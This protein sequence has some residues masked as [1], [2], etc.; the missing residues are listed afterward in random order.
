MSHERPVVYVVDDDISVLEALKNLIRS[1]GLRVETFGSAQEFFS[2]QRSGAPGCLVLDV[3]LPGLSGLDLQR[4]LAEAHIEL[5]IVF[6]T[7]HGDIR[8]SVQPMKA[9]AREF[10]VKPFRR[11]ALVDAAETT[12]CP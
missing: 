5:P 4:K 10:L 11:P 6:I 2:S 7:G 3:R 12:I 9:G 1:V 8:M